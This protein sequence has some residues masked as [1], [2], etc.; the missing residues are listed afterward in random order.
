M[1]KHIQMGCLVHSWGLAEAK[2]LNNHKKNC[3]FTKEKKQGKNRKN[4]LLS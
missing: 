2:E 4:V 1:F 3:L